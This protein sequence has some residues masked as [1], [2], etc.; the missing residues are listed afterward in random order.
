MNKKLQN[1]K[2]VINT[3]LELIKYLEKHKIEN[4]TEKQRLD[5]YYFKTNKKS[6]IIL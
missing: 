3:M 2:V 1:K 4:L 6:Q 5:I